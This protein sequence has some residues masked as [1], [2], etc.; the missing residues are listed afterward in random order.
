MKDIEHTDPANGSIIGT[1]YRAFQDAP[2]VF[3]YRKEPGGYEE[4]V[5]GKQPVLLPDG[6]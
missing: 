1:Y 2:S 4:I 3:R 6:V 5:F